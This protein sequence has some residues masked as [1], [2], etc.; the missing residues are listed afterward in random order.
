MR[1]AR[2]NGWLHPSWWFIPSLIPSGGS[3]NDRAAFFVVDGDGNNIRIDSGRGY[4]C[5]ECGPRIIFHSPVTGWD[6]D[7]SPIHLAD[8]AKRDTSRQN[9]HY[10]DD[11]CPSLSDRTRPPFASFFPMWG[12]KALLEYRSPDRGRPLHNQMMPYK[13]ILISNLA[14]CMTTIS[15]MNLG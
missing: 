2:S 9:C 12:E 10:F 6:T 7:E 4:Y 8:D 15:H 3:F 1:G 5:I 11:E 14:E 13:R